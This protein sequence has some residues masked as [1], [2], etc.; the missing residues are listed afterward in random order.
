MQDETKNTFLQKA[1]L[2]QQISSSA[3]EL[4]S[5]DQLKDI[6]YS[7]FAND[8]LGIAWLPDKRTLNYA[9]INQSI[10]SLKLSSY[11]DF[12]NWSV[13]NR[14]QFWDHTI[15]TLQIKLD[16]HYDQ[17]LDISQG[18]VEDPRWLEGARL[19]I[20][21]SCFQANEQKTAIIASD[22]NQET[23][24]L[25]YLDLKKLCNRVSNGLLQQGLKQGDKVVLYLPL[26]TE[27]VTAY[28]GIIQAGMIAVLVADSFSPQELKRRVES[29]EARSVIAFDS[30]TYGGKDL[31]IYPKLKKADV[32]PSIIIPGK[33]KTD[34]RTQDVLWEDFLAKDSFSPV[35]G[36]PNTLISI[37][38]SSGTTSEPKAIPWTQL[39]PIKCA[40]DAYYHHDI[41]PTDTLTWTTGMGWMMGP[42]TIFAA[43]MNKA[44]LALFTGSAASTA[45]G[46][47]M[48]EASISILG[49]IPSLVKVWRK[50]QMMEQYHWN[51]RVLSSTGEP[52]Q[53]ED[54]LYLMWLAKF[55]APIIEYC[56]GTEI[57]GGYLT[58]TVVQPASPATFTTPALGMDLIFREEE[59][60]KIDAKRDGEVF[61]VPPSI[62]LS[63][64]LLNRDHHEEYY[65]DS[66]SL[67]DG[68]LLRKHGDNYQLYHKLLEDTTFYKSRGRADDSMNLGGIKVSAVEIEKIINT[69]KAVYESAAVTVAPKGGG[70]EVLLIFFIP[71]DENMDKE[72]LKNDLQMMLNSEL[73]PLF[74]IKEV[75]AK[76]TLPRTASNKLMRRSL[77]K[78]YMEFN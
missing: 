40:A 32:P 34:L 77:R 78:E 8:P 36:E 5:F 2:W 56:G 9:N 1:R 6:Y 64:H 42:W 22:E 13:Q 24:T 25:T 72:L 62:G 73:N 68:T 76:D 49:T 43:L 11:Q 55:K 66:P 30:Y 65:K 51:V 29:S 71:Q 52:S 44:T 54:Y 74:R 23:R 60:G 31:S 17:V 15:Q 70:P 27:A 12:H 14:A 37:L 69:H 28:L 26:C 20:I 48:Q 47:F 53:V 45:F 7:I 33:E 16:Q 67:K 58:G 3:I 10:S 46:S 19:N 41:Q 39:T 63:Q 38:F 50:T 4:L 61:I 35:I 59:S 18:G 75:I 21:N 57:G